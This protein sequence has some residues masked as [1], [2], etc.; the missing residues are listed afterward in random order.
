MVL[1]K[2]PD[3]KTQEMVEYTGDGNCDGI[4]M[5]I[6]LA[7]NIGLGFTNKFLGTTSLI[8]LST[9][10]GTSGRSIARK[11]AGGWLIIPAQPANE[12]VV[13][14]PIM[15]FSALLSESETPRFVINVAEITIKNKKLS[16]DSI[17]RGGAYLCKENHQGKTAV[18]FVF[19]LLEEVKGSARFFGSSQI[20]ALVCTAGGFT[21]DIMFFSKTA[22]RVKTPMNDSDIMQILEINEADLRIITNA[23]DAKL[24][25]F[26]NDPVL[27]HLNCRRVSR[28]TGAL[29]ESFIPEPSDETK[30][31][32]K[33]NKRNDD[34]ENDGHVPRKAAKK[35]RV[36]SSGSARK[37]AKT[38][39]EISS[40][41]ESILSEWA[42]DACC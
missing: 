10:M 9:E 31:S 27:N 26:L 2:E 22:I 38:R 34:G 13:Y 39:E 20:I 29:G 3:I 16:G 36:R 33:N 12:A 35:I 37:N 24:A 4:P 15:N 19:G 17:M 6:C 14:T 8:C 11:N 23:G 7:N 5:T 40:D 25:V 30:A 28:N 41:V 18:C 1:E 42:N 21:S 32:A